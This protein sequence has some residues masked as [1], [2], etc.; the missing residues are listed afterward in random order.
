MK[1]LL[2]ILGESFREGKQHSRTIGTKTS[3]QGQMEASGTHIN[4][5]Y[6]LQQKNITVEVY[7]ASYCTNYDKDLSNIYKPHLVGCDFHK[8]RLGFT[9]L[10]YITAKKIKNINSYD[11]VFFLRVDLFLKQ[12]LFDVFDPN[13][14]TIRYPSVCWIKGCK[15]NNSPRVSDVM[16]FVPKKYYN[17]I[18]DIR[19]IHILNHN[20]WDQILR[21]T[22]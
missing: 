18:V 9:N 14:T 5:I 13:W 2:V 16:L 15:V 6:H 21:Y 1:G 3:Y 8:E 7:L 19:N 10:F 11:F 22:K 12:G 4:F 17:Y 20:G